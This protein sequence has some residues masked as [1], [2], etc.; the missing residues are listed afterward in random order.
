MHPVDA[1]IIF[2]DTGFYERFVDTAALPIGSFEYIGY[3]DEDG[4][5]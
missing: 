1:S 3:L 4:I 5:S 2:Q